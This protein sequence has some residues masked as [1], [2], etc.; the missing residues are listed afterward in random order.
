MSDSKQ[1]PCECEEVKLEVKV[2]ISIKGQ[3]KVGSK[4]REFRPVML[5]KLLVSRGHAM[6][7]HAR[8]NFARI[9]GFPCGFLQSSRQHLAGSA[10]AI[11]AAATLRRGARLAACARNPAETWKRTS[12]P[13]LR[14]SAQ[15]GSKS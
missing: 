5:M 3:D 10:A 8:P 15:E 9:R 13:G 14:C 11:S 2:R 12:P 1:W 4:K 6:R 7:D